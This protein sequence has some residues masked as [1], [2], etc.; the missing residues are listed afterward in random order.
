MKSVVFSAAVSVLAL[1]GSAL[2]FD[3]SSSSIGPDR[4][5]PVKFTANVFGCTGQG[6]S[7][8]LT[9]KNPPA[10]TKSYAVTMYDPDAPTGSGFWHWLVYNIPPTVTALV[11]GAGND[12]KTLPPGAGGARNDAGSTGYLGPCP[13]AGDKPHRYIVTVYALKTDKLDGVDANS[14]GALMGF[15]INSA[16]IGKATVTYTYGRPK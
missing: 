1:T 16:K 10:G 9:W 14:S 13:P 11:E 5:I 2:A 12:A 4:K 15:I 8:A 7:P 6:I 3:V